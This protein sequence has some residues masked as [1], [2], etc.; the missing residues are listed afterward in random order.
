MRLN[1]FI[2]F[3]TMTSCEYNELFTGCTEP[4]AANYDPSATIDDGNCFFID[5]DCIAQPS[6]VACV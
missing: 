5:D 1:L 3:L 2:I 4:N 6:F